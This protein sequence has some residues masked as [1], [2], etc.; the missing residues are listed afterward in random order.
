MTASDWAVGVVSCPRP[1]PTLLATLSS[2]ACAGWTDPI[3]CFDGQRRGCYRNW[4]RTLGAVLQASETAQRILIVEDDCD[5]IPSLRLLLDNGPPGLPL[6]A[7]IA[8]L[9]CSVD[10]DQLMP[11]TSCGWHRLDG[12]PRSAQGAL[13]YVMPR[14]IALAF[15][16]APPQPAWRDK[17]DKAVGLF[18]QRENI[19]YYVHSPSFVTHTGEESSLRRPGGLPENRQC[20]SVFGQN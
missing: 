16:A 18:C 8:S 14:Q 6:P 11:T 17:T 13:A 7:G 5:F 2:L 1:E 20:N 9:Y 10:T 19:P 3:V 15:D 4:R 12:L